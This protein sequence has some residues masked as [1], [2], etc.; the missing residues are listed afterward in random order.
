MT[1]LHELIRAPRAA[2]KRSNGDNKRKVAC[3]GWTHLR[4]LRLSPG[5]KANSTGSSHGLRKDSET[6]SEA[7]TNFNGSR[8]RS[9][10]SNA[11][12]AWFNRERPPEARRG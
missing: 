5:C 11:N 7:T 9:G 8:E 10:R 12:S 2:R 1:K 3:Q 6:I 4:A